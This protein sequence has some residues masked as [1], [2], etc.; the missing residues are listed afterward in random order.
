MPD[1]LARAFA[2]FLVAVHV[3]LA[4]WALVGFAELALAEVPW[5]R[6][7]NPLFSRAMLATQWTLIAVAAAIFIGGYF[8]R[9]RHTPVALLFTYGA[10]ASVC[11]Y[12]TFFILTHPARFRA[13][14][15]EYLEY[16]VILLFLFSSE[17]MKRHFSS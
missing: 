16:A 3:G 15:I 6:L 7:S 12:Q 14:A 8:G 5:R 13:M 9:W 1:A 10:M 2:L 11:A 4:G 17:A